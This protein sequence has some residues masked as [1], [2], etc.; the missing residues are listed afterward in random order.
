M[1]KLYSKL[2]CSII[3]AIAVI[4]CSNPESNEIDDSEWRLVWQDEFNG[5][6]EVD[7]SKWDKPEYNRRN[8]DTGPDG[9][10]L[11]EDSFLDGNGHL[12]IRARKIANRNS[13]RSQFA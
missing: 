7:L 12:I 13:A 9:W 3:I 2:A 5:S 4:G 8:N 6:G 1:T 11:R 10:W